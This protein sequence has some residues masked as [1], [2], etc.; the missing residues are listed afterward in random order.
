MERVEW[1]GRGAYG[2]GYGVRGGEGMRVCTARLSKGP[3]G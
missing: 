1:M 3:G 2:D